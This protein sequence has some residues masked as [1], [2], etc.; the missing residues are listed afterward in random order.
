MRVFIAL[1]LPAEVKTA[2]QVPLRHLRETLPR[3]AVRWVEPESLHITLKF[4]G[5][6][7]PEMLEPVQQANR[8]A[9]QASV[10]LDLCATGLGC[11]PNP[12][13]PRVV[14]IGLK[15]DL[16]GLHRLRDQVEANVAP[17]GFPT[18]DRPF[19]PHLTLGRVKT[20]DRQ[21]QAQV[22]QAVAQMQIGEVAT[23]H[24]TYLSL[25]ESTLRPDGAVYTALATYQLANGAK[26]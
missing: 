26:G 20:E 24:N 12:K 1:E 9:A 15:G 14:W 4:L 19:S 6:I 2:L 21:L 7:S 16:T 11:F 18:E 5:D 8:R 3:Q 10:P 25:M 22:G 17:L 13:R 23:W